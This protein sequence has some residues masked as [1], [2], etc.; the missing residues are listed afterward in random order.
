MGQDRKDRESEPPEVSDI[1]S[2]FQRE[3]A[4]DQAVEDRLLYKEVAVLMLL[5]ALLSLRAAVLQ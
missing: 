3:V 2:G 1:V 5:V 4:E